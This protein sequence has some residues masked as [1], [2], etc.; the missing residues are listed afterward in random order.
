MLLKAVI[1]MDHFQDKAQGWEQRETIQQLSQA[2]GK[3]VLS[4]LRLTPDMD[5]MDFGAGTGLLSG[6]M[7]PH[8]RKIT[9]IDTSQSMLDQLRSKPELAGKVEGVCQDIL[10]EPLERSFDVIVSAMALHH[11]ENTQ[12]LLFT[13]A[14]QLNTGGQ[15]ALAD[16][17]QEDGSFHPAETEGVFHSGFDRTELQAMLLHAGF[18]H[19]K[20]TTAHEV[21][22]GERRYPVF[23]VTALKP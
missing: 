15:I 18:E 1:R 13:F 5:V 11:V 17:D 20:W 8:V 12:A 22:K 4:H 16:L 7:A 2:V 14:Q 21:H 19:V 23:L 3:T 6:H 10:V 9:A